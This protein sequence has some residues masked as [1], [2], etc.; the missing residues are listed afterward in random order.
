VGVI[1]LILAFY[2]M[3]SLPINYAGLALIIFGVILFLLEIKVVSHGMLAIGGTVSLFLGSI[4]LIKSGGSSLE[5]V[6]ISRSVIIAATIVSALFFLFVIGTGIRAQRGRVMTGA[7]A[8][9]GAIGEVMEVLS[10]KGMVYVQGEL[11]QAESLSGTINKG[12]KV[13][14]A[15]VK[16]LKVYVNPIL[17][18]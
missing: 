12:E 8:M 17:Q 15:Y 18:T 2:S 3:N 16:D 10:P 1:S 5:F 14:V 6:R 4:M 7:T 9:T 13:Q 11:W